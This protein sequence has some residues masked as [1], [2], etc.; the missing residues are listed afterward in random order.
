[1][2]GGITARV[3]GGGKYLYRFTFEVAPHHRRDS[4]IV[5]THFPSE[6]VARFKLKRH[7]QTIRKA[8]DRIQ[9]IRLI[10]VLERTD[11][12]GSFEEEE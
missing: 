2:R 3:R 5:G 7:F 6:E 1:M 11:L 8:R 12:R 10:G 9:K 4:V